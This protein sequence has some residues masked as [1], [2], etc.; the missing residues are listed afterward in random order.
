MYPA[1][2]AFL[3]SWPY[4]P[5]LY[6]EL[7]VPAIVYLRGWRALKRH[8][9]QRWHAGRPLAF[10]LGLSAILLALAS[11]LE[12][13]ADLLLQVHMLQH[14]LLLV[15]AA[16]LVWLSQ[17]LLP[18]VRGWPREI[19]RVWIVPLSRSRS[20]KALS[21]ALTRPLVA[22]TLFVGIV[23]LWH[24]PRG[25]DLALADPLWH[26]VEHA[27]FLFAAI[28][29]WY[30]VIAPFP[31]RPRWSRWL[32]L[33][34][35]ILADVQNTVLAAWLT[36]AS[37]PIYTHYTQVPRI[38]GWSVLA[39]QQVAG[40]LMWV[41][42]SLAFLVPVVWIGL[43]MPYGR[44]GRAAAATAR[45]P[46]RKMAALP[47]VELNGGSCAARSRSD[48]AARDADLLRAPLIGRFLHWR[49]GRPAL[50]AVM[51]LLAVLVILD[52]LWGPQLS[53]ANLAG[54]APWIHWRGFVVLG[55]VAGGN[56]F[57]MACPFTLPR[58]MASRWLPSGRAWPRVLR[59]KWLA[60]ALV[61]LFLWSYEAFALWDRPWLTAWIA[62]AYFA[63]AFAIDGL[64]RGS[65]FCK[66]VCPIGQFNFVNALASPLEVRVREPA[67]C[68][69][70]HTRDCIRGS[71]AHRGCT[72][73]LFQPHKV[74]N[75]D[76]TF[77]LDCVQACPADNVGMLVTLGS[78]RLTDVSAF[79]SGIGR[80]SRRSDVAALVVLLVFGAYANAAGMIAPVV[81]WQDRAAA[82][83]GGVPMIVAISLYYLLALVVLP[84][85][86][87]GSAAEI[88]RRL[89]GFEQP[90]IR[91]ATCFAY[92][93]I[94]LG[95]A[96]W[97]AHHGFHLFT[98]YAGIVPVA[99][100][101][102]IDSGLG[103]WGFGQLGEPEWQHACCTGVA[104]WIIQFELLALG[105]GLLAS[106]ACGDRVTTGLGTPP[107][108]RLRVLAPW[109]VLMLLLFAIGVW[110]VL[111]PMQMRGTLMLE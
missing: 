12:T 78:G 102:W 33:P 99:Q 38:G 96:M 81:A 69:A 3:R 110:I 106:V 34:Y 52:G 59:S 14:L 70:C 71:A 76:C 98:S 67:V 94:P 10:L 57:C 8:D 108:R 6:A 88:S 101:A 25:Y 100:R 39:D 16:P 61:A 97:L 83:L 11:P 85:M 28:V 66:Y 37:E 19:R 29:F 109:I 26:R 13:F 20:V 30:P 105:V 40:V 64:F 15:V 92:A 73:H 50:Q 58:S 27:T 93:L 63:L 17:P 48:A 54:V 43:T 22:W 36:F 77:C 103:Q 53:A 18:L 42:G 47:I 1:L 80:F 9:P 65:A 49:Y 111:E 84:A 32:V 104:D 35:L 90:A 87:L 51:L 4:D 5:W 62:I 46:P 41:P 45:I 75:L 31:S 72:M 95:L 82:W 91:V 68:D 60:V 89:G 55:L 56:F 21:A 24:T 74:G 86:L 2:D 44:R 23:W 79:R 7:L 107:H